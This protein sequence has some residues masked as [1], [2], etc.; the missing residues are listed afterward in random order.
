MDEEINGMI[1]L[2][3]LSEEVKEDDYE[4]SYPSTLISIDHFDLWSLIE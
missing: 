4:V 3:A 2:D 1:E